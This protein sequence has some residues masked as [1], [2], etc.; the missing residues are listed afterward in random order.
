VFI[1]FEHGAGLIRGRAVRLNYGDGASS[2]WGFE[3][4]AQSS[5][6]SGALPTLPERDQK[7][8]KK[9]LSNCPNRVKW[10]KGKHTY[11]DGR[12]KWTNGQRKPEVGSVDTRFAVLFGKSRGWFRPIPVS[13]DRSGQLD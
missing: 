6:G 8:K 10:K 9:S 7:K 4:G 1:I 13:V 11:G 3:Y 2:G 5:L 12:G